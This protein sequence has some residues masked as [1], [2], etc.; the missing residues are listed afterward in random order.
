MTMLQKREMEKKLE[1]ILKEFNDEEMGG[2]YLYFLH[3]KELIQ[4]DLCDYSC[5]TICG[6]NDIESV[7]FIEEEEGIYIELKDG[8]YEFVD[9]IWIDEMGCQM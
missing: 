4:M 9:S 3:D 8:I 6:I 7:Q 2:G 1:R 5:C